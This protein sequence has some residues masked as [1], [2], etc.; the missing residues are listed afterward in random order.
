MK[1]DRL[2]SYLSTELGA[3]GGRPACWHT[4]PSMADEE[5]LPEGDD[6]QEWR[7]GPD[8]PLTRPRPARTSVGEVKPQAKPKPP[9]LPQTEPRLRKQVN[10][11]ADREAEARGGALAVDAG[12]DARCSHKRKHSPAPKAASASK[13]AAV[14]VQR[15]DGGKAA[16]RS[17]APQAASGPSAPRA[18]G[19]SKKGAAVAGPSAA[20]ASAR[21]K[22]AREPQQTAGRA[23]AAKGGGSKAAVGSRMTVIEREW[24]E[25]VNEAPSPSMVDRWLVAHY[26]AGDEQLEYS[27]QV[28]AFKLE[29]GT[30][31]AL[32]SF[33]G[34]EDEWVDLARV[35]W[36]WLD[37]EEASRRQRSAEWIALVH[38]VRDARLRAP[39]AA[40]G[41]A[42]AG[43]K[44]SGA[45]CVALATLLRTVTETTA[46]HYACLVADGVP[47]L[48]DVAASN[49]HGG[50]P[51]LALRCLG[52]LLLTSGCRLSLY[53]DPRALA[54]LLRKADVLLGAPAH[55]DFL[56]ALCDLLSCLHNLAIDPA[57]HPRLI[58]AGVLERTSRCLSL[59]QTLP[60][61]CALNL[62]HNLSLGLAGVRQR[63]CAHAD[64]VLL[65]K[66]LQQLEGEEGGGGCR[67]GGALSMAGAPQPHQHHHPLQ[68]QMQQWQAQQGPP[69]QA[70]QAPQQRIPT[71]R[72]PLLEREDAGSPRNVVRRACALVLAL[73]AGADQCLAMVDQGLL[74][75][76]AELVQSEDAA[77]CQARARA[78]GGL[79][80]CPP[81]A[82]SRARAG[83]Q[84]CVLR[85]LVRRC[86]L[87]SVLRPVSVAH[88]KPSSRHCL[89]PS[90][91]RPPPRPSSAA[92]PPT[93]AARAGD[94]A[95][96]VLAPPRR[97]TK[98]R[99]AGPAAC[100]RRDG[101]H[102]LP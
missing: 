57:S 89:T 96:R 71:D 28:R 12:G 25:G 14:E 49:E 29:D 76:V 63:I 97:P 47:L 67:Q 77:I 15:S 41:E 75:Y 62:L 46:S 48:L 2:P 10:G 56:P 40:G 51:R 6:P 31:R 95:Q 83:C 60:R 58:E 85:P 7:I 33:D 52:A 35:E 5:A 88:T 1:L 42:G 18:I 39:S 79:T 55:A 69:P 84:R 80:P 53:S 20:G 32:V 17:P 24:W 37:E 82:A 13:A 74:R 101:P 4:S 54:L 44:G 78:R 91:Q 50:A 22:P 64:G 19:S 94:A 38:A 93:P 30:H 73:S 72:A 3:F 59:Q 92:P 16:A 23:G 86:Q 61:V 87:C 43:T 70:P 11:G 45:L 99:A 90:A 68:Q 26:F 34:G 27:G 98:L 21:A 102:K 8:R 9:Q 36:H 81:R 100:V 66:V 65:A